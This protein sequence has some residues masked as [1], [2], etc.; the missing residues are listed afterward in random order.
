MTSLQ[1]IVI[2]YVGDTEIVSIMNQVNTEMQLRDLRF[3][4]GLYH[5]DTC[6]DPKKKAKDYA[7]S[8]EVCNLYLF[9]VTGYQIF[10]VYKMKPWQ[11]QV[12]RGDK[13]TVMNLDPY[14]DCAAV[15][16]V[17]LGEIIGNKSFVVTLNYR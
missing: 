8:G 3:E 6:L 9:V 2:D 10:L 5:N 4:Y 16:K 15:V 7:F 12:F 1:G 11:L 17:C 13:V 14:S